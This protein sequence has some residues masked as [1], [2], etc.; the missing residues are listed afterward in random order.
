MAKFFSVTFEAS[1][2]ITMANG[3]EEEPKT[4]PPNQITCS[5]E[6]MQN[7]GMYAVVNGQIV[8]SLT[9][10]KTTQITLLQSAFQQAE[11]AQISITLASGVTTAFGMTPHDWTKIVGLYSKYV[12]KGATL[13]SGYQ[14]PDVKGILQFVTVID[15][16]NL[17]DAGESQ[18]TETVSKLS[19]LINQVKSAITVSAVKAIVF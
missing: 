6:Q 18:M 13:S 16:E 9:Y 11:Q 17:F 2:L 8:E 12:V 7:P 10:A 15:I 4:L 3:F 1:G 19:S 14:I 5:Q